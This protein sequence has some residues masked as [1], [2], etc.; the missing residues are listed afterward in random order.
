MK[1]I[2][3]TGGTPPSKKLITKEICQDSIII[4]ADSGANCLW[5]YKITP[6]YL[7]GDF[8]SIDK[9][10]LKAWI[11]KNIPIK[12]YPIE[13]DLTDAN[14]ALK[15]AKKLKAKETVFLGALGGKRIDHL[16]G[17]IGLLDDCLK[18]NI[19]ACLK[20]D[21]QTI[22]LLKTSTTISGKPNQTF[23]LQ[24]YGGIVKNLTITGS[25]YPLKN[26]NLKMGDSLTL[27]NKFKNKKVKIS[28]ESGKLLL[29]LNRQPISKLK[30]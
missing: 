11:K 19:K 29:I 23:S 6:D 12:R 16:L 13:K 10:I 7:I 22:T 25:K 2:I 30:K 24:A 5:K 18:L 20:D 28:F 21:Y 26:Y 27:S 14:L 9:K 1:T 17:A 4:A 15:I 3:V 8:D